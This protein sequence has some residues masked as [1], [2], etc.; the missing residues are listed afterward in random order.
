MREL[1]RTQFLLCFS[2]ADL[3]RCRFYYYIYDLFVRRRRKNNY[4]SDTEIML[5]DIYCSQNPSDC[6]FHAILTV[7]RYVI[8]PWRHFGGK[9]HNM[10]RFC[11]HSEGQWTKVD[12]FLSSNNN[13]NNNETDHQRRKKQIWLV[14]EKTAL[15]FPQAQ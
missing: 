14:A 9:N 11:F 5:Q 7:M 10:K 13:N 4:C 3:M 2:V 12:F 15:N 1:H 6:L 8:M